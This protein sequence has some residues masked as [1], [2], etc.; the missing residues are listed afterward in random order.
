MLVLLILST[1]KDKP[2]SA[3]NLAEKDLFLKPGDGFAA[4]GDSLP[5]FIEGIIALPILRPLSKD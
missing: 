2:D 4:K 5:R 3:G 1:S